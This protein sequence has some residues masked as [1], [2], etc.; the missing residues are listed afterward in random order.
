MKITLKENPKPYCLTTACRV[1]FLLLNKVEKE[2][3]KLENAG[4]IEK[5]D[6]PTDWF[7]AMVPVVKPN[8]NVRI[9]VD[10]QKLNNA[11]KRENYMLP[12]LEDIAPKL[13]G[14]TLFSKLVASSGFYQIPLDKDSCESTM[15]ITPMGRYC[16]KRVPFGITLASEIFPKKMT[17]MLR[18]LQGVEVRIDDILIHGKTH[19]EH[20]KNLEDILRRISESGLKLNYEKCE[21]RKT[22][23]EYFGHVVT[24]EGILPSQQRIEAIKSMKS[25]T[26]VKELRR[27]VGMINYLGRFIP[28]L[29]SIIQPMTDLLKSSNAWYWDSKQ[30]E[31][32]TKIKDL[33]TKA[34][35]L[36][37]YEGHF[38]S[39]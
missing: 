39:S 24:P 33:L 3:N 23:I 18:N 15:F 25:P 12:N 11:V 34:P 20:D 30:E 5:V 32:F 37:I 17:E 19:E 22:K 9:C 13:T 28:N 14:S 38:L 4:I 16:F 21:F 36:T 6:K 31:S 10:L 2:L 26:N 27:I 35:V 29:A 7:A 1:A 8:N